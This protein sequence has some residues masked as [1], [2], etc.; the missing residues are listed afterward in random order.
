MP[1]KN[2]TMGG[3]KALPIST[4]KIFFLSLLG[5]TI[6]AAGWG[7]PRHP[8]VLEWRYQRMS[9]AELAK[10]RGARQDDVAL[11]YYHALALIRQG[12]LVEAEP[13]LA[14][15]VERE[16]REPRYRDA[17]ARALLDRGFVSTA[18]G[19]L[20][21]FVGTQPQ[22]PEAHYLMGRFYLTQGAMDKAVTELTEALRLR[23]QYPD[24]HSLLAAAHEDLG[25]LPLA[26]KAA[27][28]AAQQA[29]DAVA[30]QLLLASLLERT[31]QPE[32]ARPVFER[33]LQLAPQDPV[34]MREVARFLSD[35]ARTATDRERALGLAR[36]AQQKAPEDLALNG[37]LGGLL[38]A[39][40]KPAEAVPFLLKAAQGTLDNP[41]FALSLTQAYR[42]LGET[43]QTA[44]WEKE[45]QLRRTRETRRK[46]LYE[47]LKTR[48]KDPVVHEQLATLLAETGNVD[49]CLR[50]FATAQQ[51]PSDAVSVL[52]AAA[53]A[54]SN[55]GKGKEATP[56]ARRAVEMTTS[57]PLAHE[58]L[59]NAYLAQDMLIQAGQ[60]YQVASGFLPSLRAKLEKKVADFNVK[61]A[62][63]PTTAE[64][65]FQ[66]ALERERYY[67]GPQ[68][69]GDDVEELAKR[70]VDQAPQ[71]TTYLAYLLRLQMA[72]GR[73]DEGLQTA[74]KLLALAP[75]DP[76]AHIRYALLLEEKASTPQQLA[77]VQEH[78]NAETNPTH[79]DA[80]TNALRE[81]GL[82][83]VALK[84]KDAAVAVRCL[85]NAIKLD[86]EPLT[87]YYKLAQAHQ[88]AGNTTAAQKVLDYLNV[89]RTEQQAE[90]DALSAVGKD[91]SNPV[92]YDQAAALFR[93]HEKTA[94][95]VAIEA[96]AKRRFG[97]G[98]QP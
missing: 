8:A 48:P 97:K 16:P 79:L 39:Q 67:L 58:A 44:Q 55:A 96:E 89:L 18:F 90:A 76:N 53:N 26:L 92:L 81:Y 94:E 75:T 42:R 93:K 69:I 61:R 88:L 95:A 83:L 24:A 21:Q 65:S 45:Y 62:K 20:K 70:A 40:E 15:A 23:P 47:T 56:L 57:N 19:Q 50:H 17:W 7:V 34:A 74:Q 3:A 52:I 27:Q 1:E 51:R 28:D 85:E 36:A 80:D 59:G 10:A 46:L 72:R 64:Q 63:Y 71:N 29:P 84:Q 9:L 98:K 37:L 11:L 33:A 4:K 30:N 77:E 60:E 14:I 78:L 31:N 49:G 91:P 5:I 54:L 25:E 87:T 41:V 6:V 35:Q 12:R 38:L 2:T 32:K 86:P 13:L 66:R 73:R 68:K 43:T 22:L 82:G